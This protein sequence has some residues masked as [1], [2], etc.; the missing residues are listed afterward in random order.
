MVINEHK[1]TE[2]TDSRFIWRSNEEEKKIIL[3]KT[4]NQ[5]IDPSNRLIYH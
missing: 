4:T 1:L 2:L 5:N 3:I